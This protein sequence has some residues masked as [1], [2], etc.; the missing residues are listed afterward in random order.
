MGSEPL[1]DRIR[2]LESA[3]A[4]AEEQLSVIA[5]F[6]SGYGDVAGVVHMRAREALRAIEQ[7]KENFNA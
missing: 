1:E 4:L 2:R 3:L 6:T 5:D 7:A